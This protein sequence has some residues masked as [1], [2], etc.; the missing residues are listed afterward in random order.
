MKYISKNFAEQKNAV[1]GEDVWV[2]F[3]CDRLSAHMA[4]DLKTIFGDNIGRL[5]HIPPNTTN[6][7]QPIDAGLGR[8]VRVEIGNYLDEWL[9]VD[10]NMA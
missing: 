10:K 9:M 1:R 6:L 4:E 8:S 7:F 5:F 3:F 2:I